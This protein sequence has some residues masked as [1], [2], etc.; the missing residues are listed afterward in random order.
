MPSGGRCDGECR[1]LAPRSDLA[2][3][4]ALAVPAPDGRTIALFF[5]DGA[6]HATDNQCRHL[7]FPHL[8]GWWDLGAEM[9][10]GSVV[11]GDHRHA[12]TRRPQRPSTT[13]RGSS[14][15]TDG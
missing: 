7:G 4:E 5:T 9:Q 14:M 6:Y 8:A 2:D 3:A 10:T 11:R 15:A 1:N 13:P 12:A